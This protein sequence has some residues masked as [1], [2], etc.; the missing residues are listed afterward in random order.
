MPPKGKANAKKSEY[1]VQND[2]DVDELP[3][4]DVDDDDVVDQDDVDG[5]EPNPEAEGGDAKEDDEDDFDVIWANDPDGEEDE[6]QISQTKFYKYVAPADR[7]TS[8]YLTRYECARI[9]G[10]RARH[11]DNGAPAYIDTKDSTSPLQIAYKELTQK[12]LPIAILRHVGHDAKGQDLI[13]KWKLK[14]M[15]LPELPPAE[16]FIGRA[17]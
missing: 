13:E 10:D 6:K 17:T 14:E 16:W 2:D 15:T 7:E 3:D 11:L 5:G 12:R 8:E 1:I 9:L 4:D